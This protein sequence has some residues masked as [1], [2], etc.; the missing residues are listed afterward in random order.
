[1]IKLFGDTNTQDEIMAGFKLLAHDNPHVSEAQLS[2]I[3][4]NL[5]D[6]VYLKEQ[7]PKEGDLLNYTS[8]T[9]AVFSR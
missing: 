9:E 3:F 2:A 8:W 5:E 1:M 6:V 4:L 7:A